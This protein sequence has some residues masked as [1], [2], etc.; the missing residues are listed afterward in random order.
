M[1][2]PWLFFYQS[3][4]EYG[5]GSHFYIDKH[6]IIFFLDWNLEFTISPAFCDDNL[7][8][9]TVAENKAYMPCHGNYQMVT[10][11]LT[12][13]QINVLDTPDTK[14]VHPGMFTVARDIYTIYSSYVVHTNEVSHEQ[15]KF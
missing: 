2:L 13:F 15:S 5:T 1:F 10:V 12:T 11:D 4:R 3:Q 7:Y 8:T 14:W 9:M 6:S